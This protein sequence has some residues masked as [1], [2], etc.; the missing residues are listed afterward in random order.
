MFTIAWLF[1]TANASSCIKCITSQIS[2]KAKTTENS[3]SASLLSSDAE[4]EL[5]A[6][7]SISQIHTTVEKKEYFNTLHPSYGGG[8]SLSTGEIYAGNLSAV[9]AAKNLKLLFPFH[10][11]W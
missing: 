6:F 10:H 7:Q 1:C 2:A 9:I 5:S 3:I 11:F 8:S 4:L